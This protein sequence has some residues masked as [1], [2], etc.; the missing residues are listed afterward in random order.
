MPDELDVNIPSAA[1]AVVAEFKERD[2]ADT[3]PPPISVAAGIRTSTGRTPDSP[4]P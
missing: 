1:T 3:G 2:D 4:P